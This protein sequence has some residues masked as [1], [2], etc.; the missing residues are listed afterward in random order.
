MRSA[1]DDLAKLSDD[2][3]KLSISSGV[4]QMG[5]GAGRY[6]LCGVDVDQWFGRKSVVLT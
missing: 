3:A 5:R 6:M 2:L 4:T 1:F